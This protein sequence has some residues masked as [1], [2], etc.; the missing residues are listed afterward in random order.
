MD[1][2]FVIPLSKDDLLSGEAGTYVVDEVLSARVLP[3]KL[4]DCLADLRSGGP[5]VI[6][7]NFDCFFSFLRHFNE[8]EGSLR[9]GTW[10][11]LLQVLSQFTNMLP[12]IL[13]DGDIDFQVRQTHLNTLKMLCYLLTQF[14]DAFEVEATKP[15]TEVIVAG[16]RKGKSANSKKKASSYWEWEEQRDTLIQTLGQLLQLD[17][18]RLWEPP[19]VEE[20]FVN[21]I[22]GCCYK[23]LENPATV[24]NGTTKDLIFNLLGVMVKKYNH[25]LGERHHLNT[26][27]PWFTN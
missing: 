25:G 21:L 4:R 18:N 2:D 9:E 19:I 13:E 27:K 24:K 7:E 26:G 15:S 22:T 20:E 3:N 5:T 17:V 11:N 8:V 23:F 1:V 10:D 12:S 6:L 14:A 16:K